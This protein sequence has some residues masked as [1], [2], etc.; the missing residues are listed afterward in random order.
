[1]RNHFMGVWEHKREPA[2]IALYAGCDERNWEHA[3]R[4]RAESMRDTLYRDW[5]T[6]SRSHCAFQIR[7]RAYG[8][9]TVWMS[10]IRSFTQRLDNSGE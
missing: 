4:K 1:M 3:L 8:T 10:E 2:N 5:V 9:G 6:N 7:E